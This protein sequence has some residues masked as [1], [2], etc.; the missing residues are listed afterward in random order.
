MK[1]FLRYLLIQLPIASVTLLLFSAYVWFV[2]SKYD[3]SHTGYERAFL[4]SLIVFGAGF[5][6]DCAKRIAFLKH[7]AFSQFLGHLMKSL[8]HLIFIFILIV[9][10]AALANTDYTLIGAAIY[11]ASLAWT[12]F[13]ITNI[14]EAINVAASN[15]AVA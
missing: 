14:T 6:Y 5:S 1:N 10:A 4:F 8:G 2:Q 11:V 13:V 9:I 7:E 15:V 3:A 12:Y